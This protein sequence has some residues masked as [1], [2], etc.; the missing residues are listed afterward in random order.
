MSSTGVQR[1]K[2]ARLR[3]VALRKANWKNL[4]LSLLV[5]P[6][7]IL[8]FGLILFGKVSDPIWVLGLIIFTALGFSMLINNIWTKGPKP[9][10][11][12][13]VRFS[14]SL[15][16]L[17]ESIGTLDASLAEYQMSALLALT[18]YRESDEGRPR[19]YG[20]AFA[21]SITFIF[22]VM[23]VLVRL[24]E[25]GPNATFSGLLVFFS[26]FG[27]FAPFALAVAYFWSIR[28]LSAWKTSYSVRT[29]CT[30]LEER[31]RLLLD[32][33]QSESR[34]EESQLST[35]AKS[36]QGI[37]DRVTKLRIDSLRP[38]PGRRVLLGPSITTAISAA[39]AIASQSTPSLN[40]WIASAAP[41]ILVFGSV[42]L[43]AL[44]VAVAARI[45]TI[46]RWVGLPKAR[47][48]LIMA[49]YLVAEDCIGPETLRTARLS[50]NLGS[51][52]NNLK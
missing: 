25:S 44:F 33:L 12:E 14:P 24:S 23:V 1:E 36:I 9:L 39:Y 17:E 15:G 43:L 4:L 48:A 51:S 30:S 46:E 20:Y 45:Q 19:V 35:A 34:A 37:A 5:L 2:L 28:S 40:S 22:A 42:F 3:E 32:L 26:T 18:F 49:M 16:N 41:L 31:L 50:L 52:E 6:W 7:V 8:F 47:G 38:F 27:V 21:F 10:P 11:I 29:L 13:E